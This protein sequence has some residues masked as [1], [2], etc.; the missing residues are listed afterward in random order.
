MRK[1][2]SDFFRAARK[3]TDPDRGALDPAFKSARDDLQKKSDRYLDF[4]KKE[5]GGIL[6][7][8]PLKTMTFGEA[9]CIKHAVF[10]SETMSLTQMSEIEWR[11]FVSDS[12]HKLD[13]YVYALASDGR[14][15]HLWD[16]EEIGEHG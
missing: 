2:L 7:R 14:E 1:L 8:K 15:V 4:C 5:V 13:N 12:I 11:D 10:I 3:I 16:A 6:G 9:I